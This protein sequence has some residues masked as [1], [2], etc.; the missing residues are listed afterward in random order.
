VADRL[1]LFLDELYAVADS[2]IFGI[3]SWLLFALELARH[4]DE[5]TLLLTV[6]KRRRP[7]WPMVADLAGKP[8]RLTPLPP[9]ATLA[10]SLLKL[11]RVVQVFRR[12]LPEIRQAAGLLIRVPS[13]MGLVL[14][15]MARAVGKKVC[16]YVCANL[17]TQ[18]GPIARGG[19]GL[20][21]W[22]GLARGITRLTQGA[23]RGNTVF[24]VGGE[25]A[26]IFRQSPRWIP[27]PAAILNLPDHMHRADSLHERRDTCQGEVFRLLR[28]CQLFPSKGLEVL[29]NSLKRLGERGWPVEL[30]VVG[31]GPAAYLAELRGLVHELGL[32][33][34]VRFR[35]ALEFG[36][37]M[38]LY[39]QADIQV[40]SSFGEGVPRVIME[41]WSA[42]LPLVSTAVGGIPGLVRHEE[43]GLLVPPGDPGALADALERVI[44]DQGLRRR[45][46][47]HGFALARE[48]SREKQAAKL[49]AI[50]KGSASAPVGPQFFGKEGDA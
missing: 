37:V 40:I 4:F 35:G 14:A 8:V 3:H 13:L 21:L 42:S 33:S 9:Y 1:V 41:G 26:D 46:I 10:G 50:I 22:R 2:K 31:G 49:A 27:P 19:P 36:E 44:K 28:V 29:V 17:E 39:R 34:R 5:T 43:N 18:A 6:E 38:R 23:A 20:P 24:V 15:E 7:E 12:H 45:L 16:F 32:S 11:P 47:N 30:D 25:L 48:H